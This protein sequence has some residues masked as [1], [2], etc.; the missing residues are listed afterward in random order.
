MDSIHSQELKYETLHLPSGPIEAV[1][2]EPEIFI[3]EE[4]FTIPVPK[5]KTVESNEPSIKRIK[6]EITGFMSYQEFEEA[7]KEGDIALLA[8]GKNPFQPR[9]QVAMIRDRTKPSGGQMVEF[10]SGIVTSSS[11]EKPTKTPE[12]K[13]EDLTDDPDYI[14]DSQEDEFDDEDLLC[15]EDKAI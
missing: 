14:P 8:E 12:T 13:G 10:A 4:H 6:K 7:S 5:S 11:M 3:A 1:K 15:D 2:V 9:P